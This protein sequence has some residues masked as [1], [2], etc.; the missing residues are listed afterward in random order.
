MLEEN[1]VLR[2]TFEIISNFKIQFLDILIDNSDTTIKTVVYRN[3]A[4]HGQCLNYNSNCP[5]MYKKSVIT[6]YLHRVFKVSSTWSDFHNEVKYIKQ[7]LIDNNYP[8]Y[9]VDSEIN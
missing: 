4:D 5:T 1:S 9:L 3:A 2:F 6:N 8:N 7:M